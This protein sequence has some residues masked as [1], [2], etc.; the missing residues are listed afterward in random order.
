MTKKVDS[1]EQERKRTD[2]PPARTQAES[3]ALIK[4]LDD[5][6]A[7]SDTPI[8][9]GIQVFKNKHGAYMRRNYGRFMDQFEMFFACMTDY[10]HNVNY[11]DKSHWP[12][13]RGLQ[14]IIMTFSLKQLHSSYDLLV[15]GVYED[16]I[17]LIRSAYESFLRM[18]FISCHPECPA[19]AYYSPG[20][21]GARFNAT[22]FVRDELGLSW[23]AYSITSAFAHSNMYKVMGEAIGI[24][25]NK[26]SK[27]VNLD[28]ELDK[29]MIELTVNFIDFLLDAYLMAY[30]Q[31]FTIDISSHKSRDKL[32]PH[33][34]KLKSYAAICHESLKG[35][36][37]N[38]YWREVAVDVEYIFTLIKTMD[39]DPE[40]TWKDEWAKIKPSGVTT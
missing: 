39:K 7:L 4:R 12:T 30:D 13:N 10:A 36:K 32:Q 22:N 11:F 2:I 3:D 19:N 29:D 35:H 24:G 21:V 16:A 25:W 6:V 5:L 34:D 28:Y 33:I 8:L 1:S 14:F 38:I 37:A 23:T 26:S 20:Q 9:E 40:L 17:T 27:P 18:V 15:S 31:L